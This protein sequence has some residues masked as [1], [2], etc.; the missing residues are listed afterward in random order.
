MS[1]KDLIMFGIIVGIAF[2]FV[3]AI[4]TNVFP[5]SDS[6]LVP[7]KTSAVIKLLGLGLLTTS[8][9]VGGLEIKD[10]D[11]NLKTLL[12][13]LGLVLLIIYSVASPVL[14]WRIPGWAEEGS[15]AYDFRPTAA[16]IPGFEVL[17][18]L[19]AVG[20]ILLIIRYKWKR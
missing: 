4:I 13:M 19:L 18:V 3:G 11:A 2:F 8:M 17:L 6:N 9:V 7:F 16:G 5:S 10:I 14:E 15:S 20:I 1:D 12:L